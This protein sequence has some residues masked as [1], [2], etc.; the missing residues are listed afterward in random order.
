MAG[1]DGCSIRVTLTARRLSLLDVRVL[2][3]HCFHWLTATKDFK[4]SAAVRTSA[5][6]PRLRLRRRVAAAFSMFL[7]ATSKLPLTRGREPS[8]LLVGA[9]GEHSLSGSGDSKGGSC[10][11]GMLDRR[12]S[13]QI[14]LSSRW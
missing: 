1:C 3:E 5:L 6:L 10:G 9:V 4:S 7:R 11:F 12:S 13:P 8:L 14:L 2:C